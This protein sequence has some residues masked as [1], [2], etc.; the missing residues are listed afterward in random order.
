MMTTKKF[1]PV[2]LKISDGNWSA[3]QRLTRMKQFHKISQVRNLLV[4]L[5]PELGMPWAVR[6]R[7]AKRALFPSID[8]PTN[9]PTLIHVKLMVE[10]L[11]KPTTIF[12]CACR[13]CDTHFHYGML[14]FVVFALTRNSFGFSDAVISS[15]GAVCAQW[16]RFGNSQRFISRRY[17][18]NSCGFSEQ[19]A[20]T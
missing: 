9:S 16:S 12:C 10:R 1:A 11:T 4:D 13:S 19:V 6:F 8:L 15:P 17:G 18:E 14:M 20:L 3:F 5:C 2:L 7:K